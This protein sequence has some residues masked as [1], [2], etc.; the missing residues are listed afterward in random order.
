MEMVVTNSDQSFHVV[1]THM[2]HTLCTYIPFK[3]L[4]LL[5]SYYV[6]TFTVHLDNFISFLRYYIF[7]LLKMIL[8]FL[9]LAM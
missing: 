9:N 1:I 2:F 5:V 7:F 8:I 6:L 4:V 3:V